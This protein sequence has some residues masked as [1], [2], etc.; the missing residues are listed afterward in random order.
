MLKRVCLLMAMIW[1][2]GFICTA[3]AAPMELGL[4]PVVLGNEYSISLF[5][6]DKVLR[7]PNAAL[8]GFLEIKPGMKLSV[9]PVLDFVREQFYAS[10]GKR[11]DQKRNALSG[12][13]RRF[14]VSS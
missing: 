12:R 10:V 6:D 11:C 4:K 8:T 7:N 9:A 2:L 13:V 3:D 14:Y 5:M 1:S